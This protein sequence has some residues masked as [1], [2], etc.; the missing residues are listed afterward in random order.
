MTTVGQEVQEEVV[1]GQSPGLARSA[2]SP[3]I[4]NS[5]HSIEL[6]RSAIKTVQEVDIAFDLTNLFKVGKHNDPV[7]IQTPKEK[8]SGISNLDTRLTQQPQ[9]CRPKKWAGFVGESWYASFLLRASNNE[10]EKLR[11]HI[12]YG[13][14]NNRF[15]E[16]HGEVQTPRGDSIELWQRTR[17]E[18]LPS[19]L[20]PRDLMTGLIE[21]YFGR[22]HVLMPVISK[23][24]FQTALSEGNVPIPL[25]RCVL[26]V[27]SVHCDAT[28]I[29]RMGY[30]TRLDAGDD[31]FNRAK[32]CLDEHPEETRCIQMSCHF[33]LHYWWGRPS[34][35]RDPIWWLANAIRLAQSLGAHRKIEGGRLPL[36]SRAHWKRTWW[37]LYVSL[38]GVNGTHSTFS[39]AYRSVTVKW[40]CPWEHR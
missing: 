40:H 18:P 36:A 28:I 17:P 31:L 23:G 16:R 6:D 1:R 30:S 11:E 19:D 7:I 22:Y 29:H 15:D 39:L 3:S 33:L 21:A 13:S 26:F 4:P 2:S 20:P 32:K 9:I 34:S 14:Y 38:A 27:G 24:E 37:C 5:H 10:N 8:Q 12:I 35:V 25:L